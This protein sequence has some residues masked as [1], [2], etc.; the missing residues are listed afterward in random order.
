MVEKIF[1]GGEYKMKYVQNCLK[2]RENAFYIFGGYPYPP[3]NTFGFVRNREKCF[4]RYSPP[5]KKVK[6]QTETLD[7]IINYFINKI[8][9]SL[10]INVLT[11]CPERINK[12]EFN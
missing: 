6:F 12:G 4:S 10:T 5:L 9:L 1:L 11:M 2:W 8:W 7:Y 3:L